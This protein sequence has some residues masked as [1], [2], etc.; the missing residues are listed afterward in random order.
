MSVPIQSGNL[1]YSCD[2]LPAADRDAK[3][4]PTE[5]EIWDVQ[6]KL[7]QK[8]WSKTEERS[9]RGLPANRGEESPYEIPR[10]PFHVEELE[11]E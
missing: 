5:A 11:H 10:I 2:N 7:I 6:T 8:R 3:Y 9:R 1:G 4:M